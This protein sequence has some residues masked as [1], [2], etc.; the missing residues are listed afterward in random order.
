MEL[1]NYLLPENIWKVVMGGSGGVGKTTILHRFLHNEFIDDTKLTVG[2][3]FHVTEMTRNENHVKLVLWDL[4]GQPR[5]RFILPKYVKGANAA[6][7]VFDMSRI[8]TLQETKEWIEMFRDN[9]REDVPIVLV[10]TKADLFSL[11]EEFVDTT[12]DEVSALA[13]EYK[14][15]LGCVAY[16]ETSA[17]F[18]DNVTETINYVVNYLLWQMRS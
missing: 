18:G 16:I 4:G 12:R 1:N 17:K 15:K 9:I 13:V 5:F 3:Q 7:V 10:G 14:E 8:S 6:Y 11:G 2:V